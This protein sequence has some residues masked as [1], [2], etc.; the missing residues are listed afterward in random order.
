MSNNIADIKSYAL[1]SLSNDCKETGKEYFLC[2]EGKISELS[3]SNL[4][5]KQSSYKMTSEY[6]PECMSQFDINS[7]FK[8]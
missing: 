7:C 3:Q 2:I 8:R 5:Y 6:V 1:N 4:D